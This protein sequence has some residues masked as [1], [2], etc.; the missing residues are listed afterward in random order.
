MPNWVTNRIR[1]EGKDAKAVLSAHLAKD[2][3]GQEAFDFNTIERMPEELKVEK[4]SR[5]LDGLLLYIAKINPLIDAIGG[6]KDKVVP[7]KKFIGLLEK[8]FNTND[9]ER[10][11]VCVIKPKQIEELK[12]KYNGKFYAT[13]DLGK[14][15][16]DNL[17]KFGVPDWYEW[18][19]R[20]WGTKWNSCNTFLSEDGKS[21][22]FDTA[23]SPAVPA[24]EKMARMHP[25][26][27][28]THEYAEEQTGFMSGR[29]VYE[30]GLAVE[31]NQFDPYSKEAYEMSFDLW[32]NE[33]DYDFDEKIGNYVQKEEAEL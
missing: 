7:V 18:S 1:I 30:N 29:Y 22:Y 20:N 15:V 12:E 32:G 9:Y 23:W 26:V 3:N 33:E 25:N 16:F 2:E 27:R 24:I 4:S 14:K 5:S 31:E 19:I 11:G 8:A 21:V 17:C 28:I 10:I 13:I 6:K